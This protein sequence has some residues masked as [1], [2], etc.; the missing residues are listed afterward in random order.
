MRSRSGSLKG[1]SAIAF[2][3]ATYIYKR[4]IKYLQL[5]NLKTQRSEE[6]L[7]LLRVKVI[8]TFN[9]IASLIEPLRRFLTPCFFYKR[10]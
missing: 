4:R 3:V 9:I 1:A 2:L 6:F 5:F 7:V 8:D 10:S